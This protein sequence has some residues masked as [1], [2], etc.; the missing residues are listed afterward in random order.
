MC[1]KVVQLVQTENLEHTDK[2]IEQENI[3]V[4]LGHH[5]DME[6]C[7]RVYHPVHNEKNKDSWDLGRTDQPWSLTAVETT[8]TPQERYSPEYQMLCKRLWE[9]TWS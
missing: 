8:D 6:K 5:T 2:P 3:E 4:F 7:K 1:W 9:V